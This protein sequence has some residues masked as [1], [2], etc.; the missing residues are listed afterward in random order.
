MGTWWGEISKV[1]EQSAHESVETALEREVV[2][3]LHEEHVRLKEG[4][5]RMK[6]E[7][8]HDNMMLREELEAMRREKHQW[9]ELRQRIQKELLGFRK[10]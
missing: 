1:E 7:R 2:E 5:D 4:L 8:Y 10:G 6:Q 9:V 3:V